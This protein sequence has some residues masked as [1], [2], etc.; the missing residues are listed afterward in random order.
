MNNNCTLQ[1]KNKLFIQLSE[2]VFFGDIYKKKKG[3]HSIFL[4]KVKNSNFAVANK[5]LS[6]INSSCL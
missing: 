1:T 2:R 4:G 6:F 3:G 5:N